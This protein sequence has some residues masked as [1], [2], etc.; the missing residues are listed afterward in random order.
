MYRVVDEVTSAVWS[1]IDDRF[2]DDDK[3]YSYAAAFYISLSQ[4]SL[5]DTLAESLFPTALSSFER[6]L[7]GL[8]RTAL[9]FDRAD[10]LGD[11]PD[12]PPKVALFYAENA[13][14]KDLK[15]W[16]IDRRVDAFVSGGYQGWREDVLRWL[17]LD[18][19]AV[20]GDWAVIREATAR[21]HLIRR[22]PRRLIDAEYLAEIG[23]QPRAAKPQRLAVSHT[24]YNGLAD[25][26][27]TLALTLGLRWGQHFFPH[28]KANVSYIVD[29]VVRLENGR[30]WTQALSVSSTLLDTFVP[31]GHPSYKITQIN[32][33]FCRQEL[34]TDDDRMRTA[35][36]EFH[37][38]DLVEEVGIAALRRD[39]VA[40]VGAIQAYSV[41]AGK[42]VLNELRMMPLVKRAVREYG[43]LRVPLQMNRRA[44]KKARRRH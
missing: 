14:T 8:V 31:P 29:R 37:P 27:E 35:I 41:S 32:A 16:M 44:D 33:W 1:A 13:D 10:A 17:N 28:V 2:G 40:M 11:L 18:L 25:E 24:Y 20:G 15:R 38:D 36:E 23:E 4:P 12:V 6:F 42:E 26:I 3:K 9:T 22:S 21:G 34:G 7:G 43:G 39:W 5:E 19:E 30:R